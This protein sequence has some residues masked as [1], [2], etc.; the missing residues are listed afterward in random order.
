MP[1]A[2]QTA[3]PRAG[4]RSQPGTKVPDGKTA[5]NTPNANRPSGVASLPAA[6]SAGLPNSGGALPK[7]IHGTGPTTPQANSTRT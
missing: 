2:R 7:T 6:V 4:Q 1:P 5:K 3:A